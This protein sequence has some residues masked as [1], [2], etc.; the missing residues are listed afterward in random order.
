MKAEAVSPEQSSIAAKGPEDRGPAVLQVLPRLNS[1]G[2]E[3]GTADIAR[4]LAEKGWRALVA[5]AGGALEHRLKREGA[6]H[7]T[8]PLASKNPFTIAANVKRLVRLIEAWNVDL[9][10]ARSRAPAWS[11]YFAA[12]RT[13]R[14]F[15]TTFHG[16]YFGGGE[17]KKLYN[18]VMLK[19]ELTIVISRF[20]QDHVIE[21]Y[22]ADPARLRLIPRGVDV[23]RFDPAKVSQDRIAELARK[24]RL[25]EAVSVVMLPARLAEWKGQ[26]L[27]IE[28]LARLPR[29]DLCCVMV[30][31]IATHPNRYARLERLVAARGLGSVVRFVG[32]CADMPAA[33]MLADAVVSA[34]IQ[35]EA[36]GRVIVEAQAMGR[37]VIASNHG[38][39]RE[40]V[41]PGETGFL[42]PPGDA[43]ALAAAIER[44]VS[45]SAEQRAALAARAAAHV[46]RHFTVELM[47]EK[48]LAVYQ[49]VLRGRKT[50]PAPV[51]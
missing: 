50:R 2:V 25:P 45:L 41:M 6:R 43:D 5:S 51:R 46:R 35:P 11:A 33:Y 8:L 32:A 42:F 44:A 12:R 20:I 23:E 3:R 31:D 26:H 37:P 24:W 47:C 4:C 14:P 38:G 34:S 21:R 48:T 7:F 49:E 10:H 1:G 19:G 17:I 29:R 39:A 27:L 22:G 16:T 18:A 28:A 30:G 13:D 40:T 15:V 36:F 9:V